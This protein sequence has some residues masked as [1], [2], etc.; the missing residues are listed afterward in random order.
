[1]RIFKLTIKLITII[2]A[3][4]IVCITIFFSREFISNYSVRFNMD[5]IQLPGKGSKVLIFSPHNDDETLGAGE[6]IKKSLK[7]GAK[8]K[9]VLI[10]NG[11]GFKSALQLDYFNL[12]PKQND[13]IKFGY[14]R[15][16]ERI[17]ALSQLGLSKN[18]IIFLGYPDGGIAHLW[19]SNWDNSNPYKSNF[20]Q[21]NRSPYSNS[22]TKNA[23]YSGENLAS[24]ITKIINEYKP[25]YIVMP[26]PNDRH[27]DHW[28]VNAFVQ[29]T[30]TYTNY[31]PKKIWLYLVHRGDWPTPLKRNTSLY[32]VPPKKLT[33]IGTN[34]YAL[35]LNNNEINEKSKALENYRTQFRTLKPLITAFE[36]KNEL[37]GEYTNPT[38]EKFKK[39]DIE[40][41]AEKQNEIIIDPLQDTL[42]LGISR[43]ADISHIYAEISKENN[44]HI[45]LQTDLNIDKFTS[46]NINMILFNKGKISKFN[47]EF[48]DKKLILRHNSSIPI[49][50][51]YGGIK[52]SVHSGFIHITI[53][54]KDTENFDHMFINASTSI[55]NHTLDKTA[56]KMV[57]AI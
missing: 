37:F 57:K 23:I 27:P 10:T 14:T 28:A 18:N 12:F 50:T 31:T 42:G 20:T 29:Y 49:T 36:R 44:L 25:D 2:S 47:I 13:F 9:V 5:N 40:I 35:D 55:E 8:V 32:L 43:D 46:Y 41:T 33:G 21:S 7:N 45:F 22:Y 26:H 16:Q 39:S 4:I 24:D 51:T 38:I 15:Q 17:N 1:M 56:W 54:Y 6:F 52:Y 53:P 48:K 34:W 11:D 3:I 19:S 30:L